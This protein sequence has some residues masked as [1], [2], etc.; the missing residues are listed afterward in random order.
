MKIEVQD[1]V[2]LKDLC[3]EFDFKKSKLIYYHW[4][5]LLTPFKH[6]T[7]NTLIFDKKDAIKQIKLIN[8][9]QKAGMTLKE[10]AKELT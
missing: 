2:T 1:I 10:I 4:L 9:K 3:K 6:L 8:K 5:G 7:G